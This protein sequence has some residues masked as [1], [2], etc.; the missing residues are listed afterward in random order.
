MTATKPLKKTVTKRKA[1]KP[2][3]KKLTLSI[4]Q[5]LIEKG[6]LLAK[7][8]GVSLS[9]LFE[10]FILEIAKE[11]PVYTSVSVIEPN[12]EIGA[13]FPVSPSFSSSNKTIFQLRDEYYTAIANR[14]K[15]EE[16]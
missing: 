10:N 3:K 8:K 13:L 12:A 5:G 11:T 7:E 16:E 6:K 4:E 15:I 9:V 14:E 1:K 2:T